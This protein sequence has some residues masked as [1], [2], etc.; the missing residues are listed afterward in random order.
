MSEY[1]GNDFFI[2]E[3]ISIIACLILLRLI[4]V[5][6]NVSDIIY[7]VFYVIFI[8]IMFKLELRFSNKIEKGDHP[9]LRIQTDKFKKNPPKELERYLEDTR[10]YNNTWRIS[11]LCASVL[12]L[13]L[14]IRELIP[15]FPFLFIITFTVIYQCWN[16]KLHHTYNFVFKSA[17]TAL[18]QMSGQIKIPKDFQQE[19]MIDSLPPLN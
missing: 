14:T 11:A 7:I 2:A 19:R 10:Y 12:C 5:Q 15:V 13:L 8:I 9:V 6:N 1:K 18:R 16:W 4:L 3:L 17:Q